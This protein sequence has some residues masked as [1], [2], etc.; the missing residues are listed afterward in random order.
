[1]FAGYPWRYYRAIQSVGF[2]EWVG[3]YYEYWQRLITADEAKG[4]FAPIWPRVQH[5]STRDIFEH[6]F[7]RH[8]EAL[9]TV[10]EYVQR[11]LYLEAKT[12]LHGLLVV[13]DKLSM[14]HGLESRV[15]FLDN[16]LVDF[17][18]R[19]PPRMKLSHID[20]AVRADENDIARARRMREGKMILREVM[21]RHVPGEIANGDKQGFSAPDGSWFRGESVAYVRRELVEGH[22][23]IYEFMD[24]QAVRALIDEHL[25]GHVNRRLLIWSLLSFEWWLRSFLA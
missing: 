12:F 24:R 2:D 19:I 25:S 16:D 10:E 14:A 17:A 21:K 5:T 3:K 20:Q 13:E 11:S 15:P 22:P 18:M 8:R 7:A 6:V 4:V 1:M 9:P 23:R